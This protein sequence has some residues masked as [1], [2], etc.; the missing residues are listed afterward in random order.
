MVVIQPPLFGIRFKAPGIAAIARNGK[1][2]P[3]PKASMP[4]VGQ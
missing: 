1:A 3:D 4:I 2:K